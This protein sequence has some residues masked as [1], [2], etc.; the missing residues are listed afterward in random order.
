MD[1]LSRPVLVADH[2]IGYGD[3]ASQFGDLWLP[4]GA[5]PF[6]LVVFFHGGWWKSKYDLGYAGYLCSAL[7]DVGIATWSVEYRRVGQTG[8]GWPGTFH[9]AAAGFDHVAILGDGYPID[10]SRVIAMGHSA[11]G[12]LAFWIAGR[13]Q[14]PVD[15]ELS[16]PTAGTNLRGV[17]ALA[18][19]VDL[20]LTVELTGESIVARDGDEVSNLMGG[21]PDEVP[22]R[23]EAGNP[24][25]LLPLMAPQWLVQGNEDDQIPHELPHRWTAMSTESGCESCTTIIEGAG[26]FD[27]VDP[28]A[29]AW[30]D[31]LQLIQRVL[32][33]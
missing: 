4:N 25:D 10:L 11:G 28:E 9:D 30:S 26:H 19:A 15:S 8:G 32:L 6:P 16:L 23:Y 22:T 29:D 20:R 21:E 3:D 14:L 7:R 12:H 2:R 33:R 24:G 5:G 18:G 13:K 27:V 31:V 1:I 17:V